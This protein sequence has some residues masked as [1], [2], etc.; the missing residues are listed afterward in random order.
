[1]IYRWYIDDT[2]MLWDFIS[3]WPFLWGKISHVPGRVYLG[4][5]LHRWR[6][7]PIRPQGGHRLAEFVVALCLLFPC[8]VVPPLWF[9]LWCHHHLRRHSHV[10]LHDR[11]IQAQGVAGAEGAEGLQGMRVDFNDAK[12]MQTLHS[13]WH[14]LFTG[15]LA[16]KVWIWPPWT[17]PKPYFQT[18]LHPNHGNR[19]GPCMVH[20]G[21][22][23][24]FEGSSLEAAAFLSLTQFVDAFVLISIPMVSIFVKFTFLLVIES[25]AKRRDSR[26]ALQTDIDVGG[27]FNPDDVP[28]EE[29]LK[30][31]FSGDW[32]FH[33]KTTACY[34]IQTDIE[35]YWDY[36]LSPCCV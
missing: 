2:D 32:L 12:K 10:L 4:G 26:G 7:H 27:D 36:M 11:S 20:W 35:W 16:V 28:T 25:V 21:H 30:Q 9:T 29:E 1:M 13:I 18:P 6:L 8:H 22:C 34:L 23:L 5:L 15:H 14:R 24:H 3:N 31:N 33:V 19:H 17:S